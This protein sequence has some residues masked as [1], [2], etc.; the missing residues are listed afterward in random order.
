M[1]KALKV[2]EATV[3][4]IVDYAKVLGFD[5]TY[6]RDEL[7]YHAEDGFELYCITDGNIEHRNVTF[8][9]F[10][11]PDFFRNWK[12]AETENHSLFTKIE[13]V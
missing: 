3:D 13:L 8:S 10:I 1:P 2:T 11:H 12:F 4:Y 6:L 5:L 7:E 9:T